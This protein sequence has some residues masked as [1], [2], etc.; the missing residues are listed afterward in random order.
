MFKI[1]GHSK[2][3][4]PILPGT[5][6]WPVVLLAKNKKKF[7]QDVIDT[8]TQNLERHTEGKGLNDALESMIYKERLRI[9]QNPWRVDPREEKSFYKDIQQQLIDFSTDSSEHRAVQENILNQVVSRYA[10]EISGNFNRSSYR[11]ARGIVTMLFARLLN[12]ARLK[13]PMSF[14]SR[15]L[16]LDDQIQILGE[17]EHLR[18]L[19]KKG[20]VL[21]VPT[22][23]SNLDSILI[24]WVIQW[25]GLPPFI[26]GA[27]LNLF[28]IK[29]FAYFMNS[30]GAYKVDRRKKNLLYLE[31]LKTYSTLALKRGCHSLFFPGGTRSRSGKIEDRLK[32]GLL[33]T[34]VEA[35]RFNFQNPG[36]KN[37]QKIFIVP[38]VI[39]YHF[40][41]EAPTLINDHLKREGQERYYVENDEYSTSF[42]IA[43]FLIEFFTKGSGI[44][45]TVG[46]GMDI[47]GNYVDDDGESQDHKGNIID[48]KDYFI[49]DGQ[50]VE[51]K[52]REQQYTRIL[53][54]RI[55]EEYHKNNCVFASHLAAFLAF[56]MI[57]KMND[58]LD[59]FE[60]L[61]LPEED[62]VIPHS[63]FKENFEKLRIRIYK[64]SNQGLIKYADHLEGDADMVINFGIKNVGMYHTHKP[65]GKNKNGDI[66]THDLNKLYYYRNRLDSY[67]LEKY[68]R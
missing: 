36:D 27:G 60:T 50:V 23:F 16:D 6:E 1:N 65:L 7:I 19:A 17:P 10:N 13:G 8:T 37:P 12:A 67:D 18:K 62:I 22:H 28:N 49:A 63:L 2:K 20:T 34:A 25:L 52:Q 38:V 66:I 64:M 14:F 21:L 24:G 55:A 9:K 35:Q 5:R 46:R 56:E 54:R 31:T 40:V 68:I 39:N 48:A 47:L 15:Q 58:K 30:L 61:R 3:Y 4:P 43:K 41:L 29:I 32:L 33:G 57:R 42:K 59:L 11:F 51:D 45:V 26:Y 44:S 53:A